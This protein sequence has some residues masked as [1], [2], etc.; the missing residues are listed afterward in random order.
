M[1]YKIMNFSSI[2]IFTIF[3]IFIVQFVDVGAE[4]LPYL[5]K[6]IE[7]LGGSSYL[8]TQN[9]VKEGKIFGFRR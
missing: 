5:E 4:D 9:L 6:T 1:L 2:S 7:S 3:I 8:Q